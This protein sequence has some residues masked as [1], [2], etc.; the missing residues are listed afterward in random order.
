MSEVKFTQ[1]PWRVERTHEDRYCSRTGVKERGWVWHWVKGGEKN[2]V[3][4]LDTG[5]TEDD[6]QLADARLIAQSPAMYALLEKL[7][8]GANLSDSQ[9]CEVIDLLAKARGEQESGEG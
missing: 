4:V 2:V 3:A 9:A 7:L 8:K 6:R 1:G 5:L